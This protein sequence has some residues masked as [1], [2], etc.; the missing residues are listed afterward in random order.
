MR[1]KSI[2]LAISLG[3]LTLSAAAQERSTDARHSPA[4]SGASGGP[5]GFADLAIVNAKVWTVD[6]KAPKAEAVAVFGTR[7]VAV[8]SNT[9][10]R[11]LIGG[12]TRT[13]DARGKSVL[14]GFVD[15]HVHFSDGGFGLSGVNLKDAATREEFVRRIA[16]FAKTLP[17]G[18][19]ILNG[20]WDEE[21]WAG[22]LPTRQWIDAVTPDNP[23]FLDRYDGHMALANSLAM[24]LAGITKDTAAPAGGEIVRDD[25]GE[26]TGAFKDAA[27]DLISGAIPAPSDAQLDH[28]V[29]AALEEAR[30]FGVTSVD[31]I[32]GFADVRSYQRLEKAGRLTVRI[33]CITPMPEWKRLADAGILQGFGGDWI[34]MGAVKGF[35]DGSIG[36]STAYLFEPFNDRP[37]Y[38]GL[39][40]AMMYPP[41]HMLEMALD[42]DRAGLQIAVH[43]IG[44]RAIKTMLDVYDQVQQQDGERDRRWRIEHAQHV[45]PQ[46]FDEFA[47]LHVV[48][49][50]QPYHAID[51]GQWVER[52]IGH[53][54]AETSYAWRSMLDHG[55]KLAFGTDWSVAP[56]N[57]ML[58]IY[59]AVT[60][61]TLDGKNP[62]GWIPEQKITLPEAIEAY[63]MGSAYAEFSESRKGSI[64]AGKL[65]DI[66]VLDS[67]LFGVA[68]EKIRD[69]KVLYTVVGGKVVYQPG[70]PANGKAAGK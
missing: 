70:A 54:R 52:K 38:T 23:V 4:G 45:R 30:R 29:E 36:S 11:K 1:G 32:S 37:G 69:A 68:P 8:G 57:P 24:K 19:W 64:T 62:G 18:E 3:L 6:A 21:N 48:A 43:A 2:L 61:A 55:V 17:K 5:V 20:S 12:R 33:Y 59:A 49:S 67:D 34:R 22:P 56:L 7:I 25:R 42:S 31:D 60:R 58:G 47:R 15:A 63:T 53:E 46:D 41:G 39:L 9:E 13:I 44:D 26:P 65:A 27:Q 16:E 50:M 10:I 35:S 14:P 51:D 66:V 40:N 28:G